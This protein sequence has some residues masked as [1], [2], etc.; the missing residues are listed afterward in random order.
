MACSGES[1]CC[2]SL[3]GKVGFHF[4]DEKCIHLNGST[5]QCV[6][7]LLGEGSQGLLLQFCSTL[8]KDPQGVS[9][10]RRSSHLDKVRSPSLEST[11]QQLIKMWLKNTFSVPGMYLIAK[12]GSY[13]QENIPRGANKFS[14]QS[15][16]SL[17]HPS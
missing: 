15:H 16:S 2:L 3:R 9:A 12:E 8:E 6:A 13:N 7:P 17:L 10:Q 11:F 14:C 1:T 5:I 4:Q